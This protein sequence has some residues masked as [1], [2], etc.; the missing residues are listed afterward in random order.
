MV[1]LGHLRSDLS[2]KK[3]PGD[4]VVV[5][6]AGAH[7]R[8]YPA[9]FFQVRASGQGIVLDP[10]LHHRAIG[11][12]RIKQ[13]F[14]PGVPPLVLDVTPGVLDAVLA[15]RGSVPPVVVDRGARR[16]IFCAVLPV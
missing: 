11:Q 3:R 7:E 14:H 12:A 6:A 2:R 4:A 13:R 15:T 8:R 1:V 10:L 9:P 16:R 5:L